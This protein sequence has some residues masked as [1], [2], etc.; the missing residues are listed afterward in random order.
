MTS[1]AHGPGG[2][3]I[4]IASHA[5]IQTSMPEPIETSDS[6]IMHGSK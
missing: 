2:S 1:R 5:P 3:N 6:T 4:S